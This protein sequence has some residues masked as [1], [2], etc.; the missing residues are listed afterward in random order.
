VDHHPGVPDAKRH[1]PGPDRRRVGED[2]HHAAAAHHPAHVG[3]DHVDR[4]GGER[5][6]AAGWT[7]AN[8]RE[9]SPCPGATRPRGIGGADQAGEAETNEDHAESSPTHALISRR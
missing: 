1:F 9:R 7:P 6:G 3:E 8:T 2:A 4:L 5:R